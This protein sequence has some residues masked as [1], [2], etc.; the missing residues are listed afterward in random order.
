M[1]YCKFVVVLDFGD[2]LAGVAVGQASFVSQ[3]RRVFGRVVQQH[4]LAVLVFVASVRGL[5]ASLEMLSKK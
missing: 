1:T 5:E 4:Q 3:N 2:I